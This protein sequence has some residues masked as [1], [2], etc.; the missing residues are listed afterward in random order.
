M[1][2]GGGQSWLL[3]IREKESVHVHRCC[4]YPVMAGLSRHLWNRFGPE[5]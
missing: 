5:A 1:R 2:F 4:P 3:Q